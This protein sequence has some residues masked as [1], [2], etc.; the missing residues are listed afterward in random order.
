MPT[1][2]RSHQGEQQGILGKGKQE[3]RAC[4]RVLFCLFQTGGGGERQMGAMGVKEGR[5]VI[6]ECMSTTLSGCFTAGEN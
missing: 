6:P 1:P 2:T 3:Q 5:R 4:P